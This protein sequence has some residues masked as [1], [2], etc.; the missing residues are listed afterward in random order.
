MSKTK[1]WWENDG[2]NTLHYVIFIIFIWSHFHLLSFIFPGILCADYG[3]VKINAIKEDHCI[4]IWCTN[5]F[6]LLINTQKNKK[7]NRS[8]ILFYMYSTKQRLKWEKDIV[9]DVLSIAKL[10]KFSFKY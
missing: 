9:G 4:L 6:F 1:M 10:I 3:R 2:K 8:K 5:R 7:E